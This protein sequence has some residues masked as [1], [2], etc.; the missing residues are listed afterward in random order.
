[1]KNLR[2]LRTILQT[3]LTIMLAVVWLIIVLSAAN[4]GFVFAG[5][6]ALMFGIYF[7]F[8]GLLLWEKQLKQ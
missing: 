2:N 3:L 1:M 7:G 8:M 5:M 4:V 6:C